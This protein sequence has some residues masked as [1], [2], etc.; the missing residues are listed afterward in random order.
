[1]HSTPITFTPPKD[2]DFCVKLIPASSSAAQKKAT[3]LRQSRSFTRVPSVNSTDN[4]RRSRISGPEARKPGTPAVKSGRSTSTFWQRPKAVSAVRNKAPGVSQ[5]LR[6]VSRQPDARGNQLKL[7]TPATMSSILHE[8]RSGHEKIMSHLE[9][10]LK[11]RNSIIKTLQTRGIKEA[12]A[13]AVH[14]EE[15]SLL[16]DLLLEINGKP[17]LWTFSLCLKIAPNLKKIL[18][19]RNEA[20]VDAGLEALQAILHSLKPSDDPREPK[21]RCLKLVEA[22]HGIRMNQPFLERR[23]SMERRLKFNALMEIVEAKIE[24]LIK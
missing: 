10:S 8:A 1:M 21:T 4:R 2:D 15:S 7:Q 14:T 6:G 13:E 20:H 24:G 12:V 19:E 3:A 22:L 11:L 17:K 23:L 5:P 18:S 9:R 16:V